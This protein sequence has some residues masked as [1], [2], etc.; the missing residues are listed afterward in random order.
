[1][2]FKCLFFVMLIGTI[3]FPFTSGIQCLHENEKK[4]VLVS[5]LSS[6][7]VIRGTSDRSSG[8]LVKAEN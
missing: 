7:D 2:P 1:M 4:S 3:V 8:Q 6:V 5:L